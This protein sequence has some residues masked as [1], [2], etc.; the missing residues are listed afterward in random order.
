H[1]LSRL[2]ACLRFV[3]V[4]AADR[5]VCSQPADIRNCTNLACEPYFWGSG[6]TRFL[7]C[8]VD[9]VVVHVHNLGTL[10]N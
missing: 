6:S 10:K 5:L 8:T 7:N 2:P 9:L 1:R 3:L 4:F